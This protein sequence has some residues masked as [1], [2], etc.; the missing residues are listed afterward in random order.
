MKHCLK[1]GLT[2]VMLLVTALPAWA[3]T[4]AEVEAFVDE[5]VAYYQTHGRET[6][7]AEFQ[8]KEG[9]FHRGELYVF[10]ADL[11]GKVLA[12]GTI[13][14]L[15]GKNLVEMNL[16]D[17]KGEPFAKML[18]DKAQSGGG[19]VEYHWTH[20]VEKT[21]K[22][23]ASFVKVVDDSLFIAAGMYRGS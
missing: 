7:F 3:L 23:K 14:K 4:E 2:L 15:V 5:A 11:D 19:W 13:P 1:R 10:V 8:N 17:A 6:A 22:P 21:V 18:V 20:P 9:Q 16:K 12:H